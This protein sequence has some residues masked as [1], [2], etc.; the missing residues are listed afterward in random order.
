M[1]GS[2][3]QPV[4]IIIAPS[5]LRQIASST[6]LWKLAGLRMPGWKAVIARWASSMWRVF[7]VFLWSVTNALEQHQPAGTDKWG[8]PVQSDRRLGHES[9]QSV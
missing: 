4:L 7:A 3:S 5:K 1:A 2:V 9:T 6:E 8:S